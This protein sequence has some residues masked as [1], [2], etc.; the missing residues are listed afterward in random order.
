MMRLLMLSMF[1]MGNIAAFAQPND[2]NIYKADSV[3]KAGDLSLGILLYKKLFASERGVFDKDDYYNA[4][5]VAAKANNVDLAF[6]WLNK[7]LT[8]S[9]TDIKVLSTDDDLKSLHVDKRWDKFLKEV[10]RRKADREDQYNSKVENELAEIYKADQDIRKL[11]L[12]SLR[13]IP[14]DSLKTDS[15]GKAMM[16]IDSGNAIAVS[17]VLENINL[18]QLLTLSDNS[19]TTIF[20][21]VQHSNASYQEKYFPFIEQA[22]KNG[23]IK[24]Q[25]YVLLLDRMAMYKGNEQLYG[26]QIITTT[27]GYSFVSPVA[28]PI[29]LDKRRQEMGMPKMQNYLNRYNLQWSPQEHITNKQKLKRLQF[30]V[31]G[32]AKDK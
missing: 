27:A 3:A 32:A 7:S 12:A 30:E 4:A 24:K 8:L 18:N 11:Y 22:F 20:A 5:C 21:V 25:L 26:T 31:W 23:Q 15:L 19:I 1:F 10:T 17:K 9:F 29:N 13:Q 2:V 14:K 6:T 16:R 28:D